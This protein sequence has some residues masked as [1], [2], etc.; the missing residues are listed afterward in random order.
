M[1]R[2]GRLVTDASPL[3]TH[4]AGEAMNCLAMPHLPA[5]IPDRAQFD[6]IPNL[7]CIGAEKIRAVRDLGADAPRAVGL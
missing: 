1:R 6:V 5:V 4:A 7:P 3:I 2:L